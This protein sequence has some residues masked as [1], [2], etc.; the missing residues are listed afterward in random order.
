MHV[1]Y[2]GLK[3]DCLCLVFF[4]LAVWIISSLL[5]LDFLH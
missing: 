2:C 4:V 3:L 1:V 5:V